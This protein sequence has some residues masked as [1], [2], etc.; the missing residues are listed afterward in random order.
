MPLR[1]PFSCP[2]PKRIGFIFT[3][4][5]VAPLLRGRPK[6]YDILEQEI[7]IQFRTGKSFSIPF[8]EI[9]Q[10]RF[11]DQI[12]KASRPL[13]YKFLD[14]FYR[15]GDYNKFSFRMW[16]KEV[17]LNV[18]PPYSFGFGSRIGEVHV[19]RKKG[20]NKIRLLAPWLNSPKKSKVIS[21]TPS[22]PKE[23]FEQLEV[24]YAKWKKQHS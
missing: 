1:R 14:P 3:F 13:R 16:I 10:F 21:I 2:P 9:E 19:Y 7:K 12:A 24:A 8:S 4:F 23:F 15:I 17:V 5:G 22:D 11:F 20:F 18:L 6:S